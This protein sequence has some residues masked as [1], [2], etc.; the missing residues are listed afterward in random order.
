MICF[1]VYF[2]RALELGPRSTGADYTKAVL[3]AIKK[4]HL[5]PLMKERLEIVIKI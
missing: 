1:V 3:E 4:D 5:L 2:W